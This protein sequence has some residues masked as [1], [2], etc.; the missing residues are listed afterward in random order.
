MVTS[1]VTLDAL[2]VV[3][4]ALLL[5]I[6]GGLSLWLDLRLERQLTVAAA[7][8]VV[9]LLLVGLVLEGLFALVSPSLTALVMSV[10]ALFAAHEIRAR[11]SRNIAGWWSYGIGGGAMSLA[12]FLVAVFALAVVVQP[13]PWYHPQYAIPLF[14]MVLGNAMTG[15]SLGLNTLT[16]TMV[17]ERAAIEAQLM[18]GAARWDALRPALRES[19]RSGFMP[20]INSMAAAGVVFLPGMMTGQILAGVDPAEAVKYQLVI[21]FLIA[22]ATGSGVLLATFATALRLTD[23]R[24]RLRLDRLG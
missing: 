18:L 5:L 15:I 3:L 6:N 17:R 20:I 9:Q 12:G 19:L 22:G 14:G 1:Y 10:M 16:T 21:M 4:A 24:H 11:Q 2:D 7:R 13:T 23:E 8:M